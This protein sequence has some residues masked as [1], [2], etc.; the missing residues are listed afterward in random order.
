MGGEVRRRKGRRCER[1]YRT[2]GEEKTQ[3][4]ISYPLCFMTFI[5]QDPAFKA[6]NAYQYSTS[7]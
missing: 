1:R 3:V 6:S 2:L 4:P 7:A 5:H